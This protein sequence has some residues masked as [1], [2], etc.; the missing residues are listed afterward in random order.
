MALYSRLFNKFE[1]SGM[2]ELD[3][4]EYLG[5]VGASV[6]TLDGIYAGDNE[7]YTGVSPGY[8]FDQSFHDRLDDLYIGGFPG[9]DEERPNVLIDV[10]EIGDHYLQQDVFESIEEVYDAAY[11]VN[12][13]VGRREKSFPESSFLGGY[14]GDAAR[15][16]G[17]GEYTGFVENRVSRE[18]ADAAIQVIMTPGEEEPRQGWLKYLPENAQEAIYRAGFT[19]DSVVALGSDSALQEKYGSEFLEGKKRLLLHEI[20]H[21][22][23]IT[24]SED[25]SDIMYPDVE[26]DADLALEG[27][28]ARE[29]RRILGG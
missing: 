9:F 26:V 4:R 22:H 11:D 5:L 2:D 24:H 3:R 29:L 14:G 6:L 27:E 25:P 13:V 28:E 8:M 21:S 16:L 19:L 12:A 23:G 15:I 20:Y 1:E 18:L 17:V 7:D 10:I